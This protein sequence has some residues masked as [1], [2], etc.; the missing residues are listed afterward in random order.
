[1]IGIKR[2]ILTDPLVEG[3]TLRERIATIHKSD[4]APDRRFVMVLPWCCDTLIM[5]A[6]L[7]YVC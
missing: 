2:N 1:V 5:I 4:L 7:L 3:D 6:N